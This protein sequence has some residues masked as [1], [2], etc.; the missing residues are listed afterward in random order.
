MEESNLFKKT[1]LVLILIVTLLSC[2]NNVS[3][4]TDYV[5]VYFDSGRVFVNE[6]EVSNGD[7]LYIANNQKIN[8][9]CKYSIED[10]KAI[11][12]SW[13]FEYNYSYEQDYYYQD[14][15][16]IKINRSH[17]LYSITLQLEE[18]IYKDMQTSVDGNKLSFVSEKLNELYI[19]DLINDTER[20]IEFL[21]DDSYEN[22][23]WINSEEI[24]VDFGYPDYI[25]KVY[26]FTKNSWS[27]YSNDLTSNIV[28]IN[29]NELEPVKWN[30][31]FT[32]LY[33]IFENE[34]GEVICYSDAEYHTVIPISATADI[35]TTQFE[36][37]P[38]NNIYY[39]YKDENNTSHIKYYNETLETVTTVLETQDDITFLR[40]Y[41]NNDLFYCIDDTDEFYILKEDMTSELV[42]TGT[43]CDDAIRS[44]E[45]LYSFRENLD[46]YDNY[47]NITVSDNGEIT[48]LK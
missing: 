9:S 13:V 34:N 16:D 14:I 22:H 30:K 29:N 20:T 46:G 23:W 21:Y 5:Y 32:R 25:G 39:L 7:K 12:S 38:D 3:V 1:V 43:E 8:L 15:E 26:N 4:E 44:G 42:Y 47:R 36:I 31:D 45:N 37:T 28:Q 33:Y 10:D 40:N 27:T 2:I 11:F 6:T 19:Y 41:Y 35:D 24:V 18:I 48:V 17:N